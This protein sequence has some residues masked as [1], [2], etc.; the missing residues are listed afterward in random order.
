MREYVLA[1]LVAAAVTY[2]LVPVVRMLAIRLGVIAEIRD[3]DVHAV[4]I[5]RLGGLAMFGGLCA[6]VLVASKLPYLSMNVFEDTR[7]AYALL[8]A[9]AL[10]VVTGFL[11]DWWEMD[12]L[13]KAGGQVGAAGI[14]VWGG[15]TL[16]WLPLPNGSS[17]GL[18]VN[19][20]AVMTV[21]VVV[22]T[23][24]AVNFVDGLD[25]LAAGIVGIA[26]LGTLLYAYVLAMKVGSP[27]QTAA[28]MISAVLI[29]ICA[30]FL[31][32]NFHPARIFMGDTG[33]MLI[34]LLLAA[35][36]IK[37]TE[38]DVE[39]LSG[40]EINR[41]PVILPLLLPVAVLIIPLVD[42]I[43]AVV[44]RTSLGRSPFA[45]D[46][47]HLHHRLLEIGHSQRRTVLIMYL[48]AAVF[49]STLV[50]LSLVRSPLIT[51]L[52]TSVLAVGVL[53]LMA[54]LR[55]RGRG[56]HADLAS[57]SGD[58][59]DSQSRRARRERSRL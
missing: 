41:Y 51:L 47:K 59:A 42:L 44:R 32:H 45:P 8:L 55:L 46:K 3:R 16:N 15:F 48:W 26:A 40:S 1:A 52:M 39:L 12:A 50:S 49:S 21:L 5:P 10:I 43:M 56:A 17:Y 33:S 30:G 27:R 57:G 6:G 34:G 29:G 4:P 18:D 54:I 14:L 19:L 53:A 2:L 37:L 11:D 13:L 9:C 31:P 24:N 7:T 38:I 22:V 23:I 58:G 35:S 28:L 25:G 36:M 20:G